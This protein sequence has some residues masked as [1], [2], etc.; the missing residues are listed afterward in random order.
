MSSKVELV[1]WL[2]DK[3]DQGRSFSGGDRNFATATQMTVRY[4][5]RKFECEPQVIIKSVRFLLEGRTQ[6]CVSGKGFPKIRRFCV[7]SG[8]ASARNG[9]ILLCVAIAPLVGARIETISA[10]RDCQI[11]SIA[12]LVGAR[13]ETR[14]WVE[15][16]KYNKTTR[17]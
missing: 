11:L 13:I 15:L 6:G 16:T 10:G 7:I 12:P 8:C 14:D 5:K 9:R 1:A 3:V 2:G 17:S 4:A